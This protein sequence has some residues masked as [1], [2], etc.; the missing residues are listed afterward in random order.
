MLKRILKLLIAYGGWIL[1]AFVLWHLREKFFFK[2]NALFPQNQNIHWEQV[3]SI[4]Q[5]RLGQRR[6]RDER[7]LILML[8][9]SHFEMANW[10]DL[11]DGR[12][13]IRNEGL[14]QAK[15]HD[16]TRLAA[17]IPRIRPTMVLLFCGINDLGSGRTANQALQD[18]I[19]LLNQVCA[20]ITKERLVIISIM[21]VASIRL[22]DGSKDLNEK[23]Q[24]L[25]A[26]LKNYCTKEGI[27]YVD[28]SSAI[29][30]DGILSEDL[31]WD[32]LHL[33]SKGY[34]QLASSI[35]PTLIELYGKF[36][37]K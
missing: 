12:F 35:Q 4:R 9:D 11:F 17:E 6:W 22:K 15:I 28:V 18:Y 30:I 34:S 36:E 31:T 32:G 33:N 25:N 29:S 1:L 3:M 2:F 27:A 23:V 5:D 19:R 20:T 13:A 21:P 8:G 10:Y 24:T 26:N 14:S 37:K 7:P 16:V